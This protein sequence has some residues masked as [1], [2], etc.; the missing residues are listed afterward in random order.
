[1]SVSS[2]HSTQYVCPIK[3]GTVCHMHTLYSF[4]LLHPVQHGLDLKVFIH[5][6]ATKSTIVLSS[7]STRRVCTQRCTMVCTEDL[8]DAWIMYSGLDCS[9]WQSSILLARCIDRVIILPPSCIFP[10]DFFPA[11]SRNK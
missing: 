6:N 1:M 10:A 4:F 5:L 11:G 2:S 3:I 8:Q 7:E 9:L